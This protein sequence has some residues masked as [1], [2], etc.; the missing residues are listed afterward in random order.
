MN[1]FDNLLPYHFTKISAQQSVW[2]FGVGTFGRSVA[3]ACLSRGIEVKGFIQTEPAASHCLGIQVRSW[4]ELSRADLSMPLII[5]IFNRDTPLDG[6][7]KLAQRAGAENIVMPWDFYTQAKNELGWRFWLSDPNLLRSHMTD[8]KWAYDR[9]EDEISRTCLERVVN[10]RSGLDIEYASYIDQ[11]NQY[12][13]DLTIPRFN[14]KP[15]NFLDGGAFDGGSLKMLHGVSNVRQAWLFEPDSDNYIEMTKAVGKDNL[16]GYCIPL[17]LSDRYGLLNFNGGHGESARIDEQGAIGIT[18]VT[19]DDF[20][21]GQKVD[22]IK[23]DV[24]GFEASVLKG[25]R[26]T[27]TKH[28]PVI[29]ASCYHNPTDLWA[30]PHLIHQIDNSY[31]LYLRQH[32]FNSFDLV[33][34]A[35]PE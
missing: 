20:L 25:A 7:V 14:G 32:E 9:F 18:T 8:L 6:L 27:I 34:Y 29:A 26:A 31:R 5:G 23:L 3:Q 15:L 4:N 19:I 28:K 24:E 10:F 12:F 33:L 2:V 1:L 35:V 21:S 11:D 13:N 30:L 17:G 16:P 22:F